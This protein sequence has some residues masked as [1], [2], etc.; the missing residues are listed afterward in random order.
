MNF[1][2]AESDLKSA[3]IVI[4]GLP[5][6]G[7]VSFRPGT[8]F[9]P[10]SIRQV[11]DVIETYSPILDK[12]LT[13]YRIHDAGDIDLTIGNRDKILGEIRTWVGG[14]LDQGK[15]VVSLGGEHLV[16]FPVLEAYAE[17]YP[18]LSVVHLDA[19]ADLREDYMGEKNSHATVMRRVSE[20]IGLE[21]IY[22]AGIRSGTREEFQMKRPF[23]REQLMEKIS[24]IQGPVYLTLDLDVLDPSIFPGTGTPEPGGWTFRELMEVIYALK[25][26]HV[27]GADI[28]ELSPPFDPQG[29]S[30][31]VAAKILREI[32]LIMSK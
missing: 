17:K 31:I 18:G 22:T 14:F 8:R 26:N 6:D 16:S 1:I 24:A 30:S 9:G 4:A 23:T 27:V 28:V 15:K 5:Y 19:H 12:D 20:L 13:D 32:L 2:G 25:G 21:N 3:D 29:N 10:A 11:S 7:T